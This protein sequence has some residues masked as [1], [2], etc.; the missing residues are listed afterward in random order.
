MITIRKAMASDLMA[1]Q[2]C[3]L[4]NLAENYQLSLYLYFYS[5]WP[6]VSFV[7]ENAQGQVVGYVLS[8]VKKEEGKDSVGYICSLSVIR[9]YRRLGIAQRLMGQAHAAMVEGYDVELSTLNVR[10]S[11]SAAFNL[12]KNTLAYE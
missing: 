10:V 12:Y 9:S 4:S 5:G 2:H 7:A 6:D 8:Y 3:N 11:N 1:M